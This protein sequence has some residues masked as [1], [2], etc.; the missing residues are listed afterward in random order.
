MKDKMEL[1]SALFPDNN[2]AA[3]KVT[4]TRR[5]TLT[6]VLPSRT[7]AQEKIRKQLGKL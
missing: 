1:H 3:S 5:L 6:Q 2:E 4:M 7:P